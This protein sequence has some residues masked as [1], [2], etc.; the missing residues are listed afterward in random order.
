VAGGASRHALTT[1]WYVEL[2]A[3]DLT[4][5]AQQGINPAEIE[6][7]APMPA[8]VQPDPGHEG[9]WLV[10]YSKSLTPIPNRRAIAAARVVDK[11][12]LV[13]EYGKRRF[14]ASG[15]RRRLSC[16]SS[17]RRVPGEGGVAPKS[18]GRG[19]VPAT[20]Q[21]LGERPLGRKYAITD[22]HAAHSASGSRPARG[23]MHEK[24]PQAD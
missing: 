14:R 13:I 19:P 17:E 18:R 22:S 15:A 21:K 20:P 16:G 24:Q 10:I 11:Q 9:A 6:E 12:C 7:A 3:E 1:D 4:E 2:D 5:L 23:N 8:E